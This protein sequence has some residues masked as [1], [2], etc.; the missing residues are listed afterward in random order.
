M[1]QDKTSQNH[2]SGNMERCFPSARVHGVG[3]RIPAKRQGTGVGGGRQ[4]AMSVPTAQR[5]QLQR[6]DLDHRAGG[7]KT[8]RSPFCPPPPHHHHQGWASGIGPWGPEWR[9]D[10]PTP[11]HGLLPPGDYWSG[12]DTEEPDSP[13]LQ[14]STTAFPGL[15]LGQ[16]LLVRYIH[17]SFLLLIISL[18]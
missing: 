13:L 8:G 2:I 17:S 16:F 5:G 12:I 4:T 11:K 18:L 10:P 7:E 15:I 9:R 3:V 1:G 6:R 14:T